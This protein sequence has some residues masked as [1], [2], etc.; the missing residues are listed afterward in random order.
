MPVQHS[1]L[2]IDLASPSR[3]GESGASLSSVIPGAR[4]N[5]RGFLEKGAKYMAQ[6]IQWDFDSAA[7]DFPLFPFFR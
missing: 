5:H 6:R 7:P 1:R 2:V 4:Q 3:A